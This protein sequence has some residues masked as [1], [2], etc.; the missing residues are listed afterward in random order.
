LCEM[1][2]EHWL[3]CG[4]HL[5]LDFERL[6]DLFPQ[7][8]ETADLASRVAELQFRL[9]LGERAIVTQG[10]TIE[11]Y[12]KSGDKCGA[13]LAGSKLATWTLADDPSAELDA[14][15]EALSE[16]QRT[17]SPRAA[18]V[19]IAASDALRRMGRFT[20]ALLEMETAERLA[21]GHPSVAVRSAV[22]RAVVH[23]DLGFAE[24]AMA[25]ADSAVL[26]ASQTRSCTLAHE[27]RACRAELNAL[28]GH[29]EAAIWDFR[30]AAGMAMVG[31]HI[32]R[33]MR[34]VDR[35]RELY[36]SKPEVPFDLDSFGVI[37][38]EREIFGPGANRRWG[39]T[40]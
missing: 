13:A 7:A 33:M 12:E 29:T 36:P 23:L 1:E 10:N 22:Q 18:D 3:S 38:A 37:E 31:G 8:F 21:D 6:E 40:F 14:H 32:A 34:L 30:A 25:F 24:D 4:R 16:L 19:M 17:G 28:F 39:E 27:A 11:L 9:G 5:F 20:E 26:L 2:R 35:A 15:T